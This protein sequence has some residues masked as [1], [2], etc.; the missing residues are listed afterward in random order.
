MESVIFGRRTNINGELRRTR[1]ENVH[2]RLDRHY[3]CNTITIV[4][5]RNLLSTLA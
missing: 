2:L 1:V 3:T 4:I 5:S